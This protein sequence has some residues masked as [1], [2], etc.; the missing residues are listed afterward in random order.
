MM[1]LNMGKETMI[2]K[3]YHGDEKNNRLGLKDLKEM[4]QDLNVRVQNHKGQTKMM[5][6]SKLIK[7]IEDMD[8]AI[9]ANGVMFSKDTPSVFSILFD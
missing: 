5:E 4:P 1:T 2:G 7:F 9:A 3:I 8:I 6:V